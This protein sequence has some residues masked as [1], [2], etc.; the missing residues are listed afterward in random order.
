MAPA[1]AAIAAAAVKVAPR[2]SA[3]PQQSGADAGEQGRDPAREEEGA[4][5]RRALMIGGGV[6]DHPA[7]NPLS[8][9]HVRAPQ[10]HAHSD[11]P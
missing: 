10:H 6:G 8:Q 2:T 4:K 11:R 5:A 3:I 1:T 9:R 7:E